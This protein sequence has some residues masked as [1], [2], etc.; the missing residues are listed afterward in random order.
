MEKVILKLTDLEKKPV[1]MFQKLCQQKRVWNVLIQI[2]TNHLIYLNL[3]MWVGKTKT[4]RKEL[5]TSQKDLAWYFKIINSQ[6]PRYLSRAKDESQ[7][8]SLMNYLAELY[9]WEITKLV[10]ATD[11]D[12]PKM[13]K[14]LDYKF[15]YSE[16]IRQDEKEGRFT[17]ESE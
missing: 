2:L 4:K 16:N 10:H 12:N 3:M 8:K 6:H 17:N 5:G 11:E 15:E 7:L 13:M 1:Q 14:F 9:I